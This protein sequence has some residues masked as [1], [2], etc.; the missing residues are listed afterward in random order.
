VS[1]QDQVQDQDQDLERI[2]RSPKSESAANI[3]VSS[4]WPGVRG[5][6]LG[7]RGSGLGVRC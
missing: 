3:S 5:L 7:V 6:G 2:P 4:M 1:C